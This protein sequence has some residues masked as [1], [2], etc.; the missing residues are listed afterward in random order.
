MCGYVLAVLLLGGVAG[1]L[2]VFT[3]EALTLEVVPCTPG[4][5]CP[6]QGAEEE[7]CPEGSQHVLFEGSNGESAIAVC[8]SSWEEAEGL[9][10]GVLVTLSPSAS[11]T[12]QLSEGLDAMAEISF[13]E[14]LALDVVVA[15]PGRCSRFRTEEAIID[16]PWVPIR[17]PPALNDSLPLA[18]QL[19]AFYT[20]PLEAILISEG[21]D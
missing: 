3:Q 7:P 1:Q 12:F 8:A 4:Y 11:L 14:Y 18:P 2:D 5:Y 10:V 20:V 9:D 13:Q 17:A 6:G 15:E 21:S 16:C 19:G